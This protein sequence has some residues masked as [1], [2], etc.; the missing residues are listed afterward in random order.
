MCCSQGTNTS[1]SLRCCS[2]FPLLGED[3]QLVLLLNL[4]RLLRIGGKHLPPSGSA[5]LGVAKDGEAEQASGFCELFRNGWGAV[6][7][8]SEEAEYL[9][10]T[11]AKVVRS[12]L[13]NP[14]RAG[15]MMYSSM[16]SLLTSS[17]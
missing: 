11:S 15:S 7:L 10:L 17:S 13:L 14:S 6:S 2:S 8:N 3:D 9:T 5:S 12:P 1:Q 4:N 16:P